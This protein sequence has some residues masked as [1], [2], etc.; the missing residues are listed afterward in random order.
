MKK[1]CF[2]ISKNDFETFYKALILGTTGAA[3]NVKMWFFFTFWGLKLI[4]K[5]NKPRVAGMRNGMKRMAGWMFRRK[6][7]KFGYKDP[8]EMLRKEV[9]K[10]NIK[11]FP[12][13]MTFEMMGFKKEQMWDFVEEPVGAAAFLEMCGD[14]DSIIHM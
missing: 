13:S 14:A 7:V 3:M 5:G 1:T 2:I 12:C 8:E 6:L 4:R 11:L 10:G 9:K